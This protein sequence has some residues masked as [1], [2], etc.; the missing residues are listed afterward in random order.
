MCFATFI[1]MMTI[2]LVIIVLV[3]LTIGFIA[4]TLETNSTVESINRDVL[5]LNRQINTFFN[6]VD[7]AETQAHDRLVSNLKSIELLHSRIDALEAKKG[8]K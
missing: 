2:A 5:N 4:D 3:G 7:R 8:K 1:G 6:Q